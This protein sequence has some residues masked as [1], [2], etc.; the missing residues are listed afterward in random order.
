MIGADGEKTVVGVGGDT[1]LFQDA[2]ERG[3][4]FFATA[5]VLDLAVFI[6]EPL[7]LLGEL[8]RLVG[9]GLGGEVDSEAGCVED[10]EGMWE[11]GPGESWFIG[12]FGREILGVR[13]LRC[14]IFLR[15]S[16]L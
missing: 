12:R 14:V 11:F 4:I 15:V 1:A 8:V 6:P 10:G 7:V 16:L 13:C 5:I 2:L 9:G 3:A